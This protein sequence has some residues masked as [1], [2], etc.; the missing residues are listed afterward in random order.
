[1]LAVVITVRWSTVLC[2]V[3]SLCG[4]RNFH[5]SPVN[6]TYNEGAS[7]LNMVSYVLSYNWNVGVYYLI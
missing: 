1:M 2:G 3:L 6:I 4:A 7:N 5:I